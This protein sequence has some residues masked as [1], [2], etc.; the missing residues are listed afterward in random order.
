MRLVINPAR[1]G[2]WAGKEDD[3][4]IFDFIDNLGGKMDIRGRL[5]E[6]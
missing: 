3:I 1:N 2:S 6:T 5:E 4:T